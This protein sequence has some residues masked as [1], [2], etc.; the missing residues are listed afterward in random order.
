ML[1]EVNLQKRSWPPN[2]QGHYVVEQ[3][4]SVWYYQLWP[5]FKTKTCVLGKITLSVCVTYQS[6][7]TA[8]E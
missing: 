4:L 2:Q 1:G 3:L 6:V 8:V 7:L 5:D